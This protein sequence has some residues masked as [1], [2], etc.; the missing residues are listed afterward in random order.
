MMLERRRQVMSTVV[1]RRRQAVQMVLDR[2][3]PAAQGVGR[4]WQG[5]RHGRDH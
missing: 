5:D 2:R 1:D 4:Q 3:Q